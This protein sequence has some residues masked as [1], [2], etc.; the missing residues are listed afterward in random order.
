MF[1]FKKG[2]DIQNRK[3]R[4]KFMEFYTK[5]DKYS[6][7]QNIDFK[8]GDLGY[9]LAHY[10]LIR[11]LRPEK[12]LCI[13]SKYGFIPAICALACKDN[14]KGKVDFV[15]A[16]LDIKDYDGP[17]EHWG[18]VGWWKKCN[19]KEYFG[20]FGLEKFINLHVMKTKDFFAKYGKQKYGYVY[21]DGDHSYKGVKY[22]FDTFWPMIGENEFLSIHDIFSPD[23]DGNIYGTRRF[24]KELKKKGLNTTEFKGDAGLG[25]IQK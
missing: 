9:G 22:D 18:G 11:L 10:F 15:D 8:S 6:N 7:C 19:P 23:R 21:I 12:I 1:G 14:K 17:G 4:R 16:G 5:K 20:K 25:F 2:Q 13:G 3:W 24:W